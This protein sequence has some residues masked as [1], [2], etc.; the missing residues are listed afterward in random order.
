MRGREG[1]RERERA[2]FDYE[3][4]SSK[5][6]HVNCKYMVQPCSKNGRRKIT[7]NSIEVD[8]ETKESTRKTEEKLDRRYKE[9]HERKKPK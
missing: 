9:G 4:K 5:F 6:L 2:K 1:E 7:Q 3:Q 8:A